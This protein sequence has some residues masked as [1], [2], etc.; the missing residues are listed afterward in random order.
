MLQKV[1][2]SCSGGDKERN[3]VKVGIDA[4]FLGNHAGLGG[5]LRRVIRALARVDPDGDY[6]LFTNTSD[7]GGP[8]PDIGSMHRVTVPGRNAIAR[9]GIILPLMLARHGVDVFHAQYLAP[10]LCPSKI[11]V[12]IHDLIHERYPDFYPPGIVKRFRVVVPLTVRRASAII[13]DSEYSKRDIVR[14]YRVAPEKV[15]VALCAADSIFQ[16]IHDEGRLAAVRARYGTGET[17]LLCVGSIERRKN[18]RALIA[19]YVKLRQADTTRAK[20][21]LVGSEGWLNDDIFTAARDSGYDGDLVFTGYIPAEDLVALYNAATVFV[22]PSLFEGFGMP[23][24]EAMACGTP[25]VTSNAS[26]LPEVVGEAALTVDP[27]DI[28]ALAK[29]MAMALGNEALRSELGNRG[30]R[31]AAEFSWESTARTISHVYR[32][33]A[34]MR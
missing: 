22:Y 33:V 27:H 10:P 29:A 9:N 1:P 3:V 15:T 20:L 25:V 26:S 31:R 21:V 14:R 8:L 2:W 16:P 5:Y 11:V 28:E 30:L 32:E 18:L 12:T 13:T 17:F 4:S 24:L 6:T 34:K 19:A 23:P 7:P